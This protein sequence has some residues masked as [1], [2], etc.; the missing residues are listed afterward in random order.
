M[1]FAKGRPLDEQASSGEHGRAGPNSS[2]GA[3]V[4]TGLRCARRFTPH[5][6]SGIHLIIIITHHP[7][8]VWAC[9]SSPNPRIPPDSFPQ[10]RS[11][12]VHL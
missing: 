11:A 7:S 2:V 6:C 1:W 10:A 12:N 9:C 5:G 3:P 4:G 8:Q